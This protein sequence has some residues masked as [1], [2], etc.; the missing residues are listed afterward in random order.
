MKRKSQKKRNGRTLFS[1]DKIS[2]EVHRAVLRD[3]KPLYMSTRHEDHLVVLARRQSDEL[4]K[5][6]VGETTDSDLHESE[7][8]EAFIATNARLGRW[9]RDFTFPAPDLR[10]QRSM[11]TDTK[12]LLRARALIHFVL[13]PFDQDEWFDECKNSSGSSLGVPF[14]DTSPERKLT[15]PITVTE[16]A[17]PLFDQYLS[18]D[19][20]LAAA[21]DELNS[22]HPLSGRYEVV[23]GSRAT[24]VDKTNEK[25][26]MIAIEPTANM[27]LQQGL[28]ELLYKRLSRV[29]L[30]VETLPAAHKQLA[31]ESSITGENATIDFS[32][33]SDCVSVE[34]LRWLLPP[35]WFDVVYRTRSPVM[36]LRGQPESLNMISTMGN[37]VT[38]PLETLV[39]WAF[40]NG[41]VLSSN[42][43]TNSL[44][45][46]WED[47]MRCS[48]FGDDCIVPTPTAVSFME[49]MEK[50]GFV[51]NREK[52]FFDPRQKFRESCG[53]DYHAGYNVRPFHLKAPT[54][55]SMASL[56]PWLYIILNRLIPKYISCFGRLRYVYDKELFRV[57]AEVFKEH[58]LKLKLV[59]PDYP[60]DAGL[61]WSSDLQRFAACYEWNF[62]PIAR[63]HHGTYTFLACSFR[64]K[65]K[66]NRDDG[67]R[68]TMWLKKPVMAKREPPKWY[69]RR[70]IGG[71]VVVRGLSSSWTIPVVKR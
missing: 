43:R 26:R 41:T 33:A 46:E 36:T 49:I 32:S 21:V 61:R 6:Y 11:D 35:K 55:R 16:M 45:P 63:S 29:G 24:T 17:K 51:V 27:F 39:F 23:E 66:V 37:A 65:E 9:A 68:Y 59:P 20:Q 14:K 50:V 13:T 4:L 71:Y 7:A 38:F 34:L 25:R 12:T 69:K 53:G 42:P 48:V 54:N 40:A 47:L 70:R 10:I 64:Y 28:M 2:T 3:L 15:W 18:Y 57:I 8:F 44:F 52:S 67:I 58:K 19:F 56:E 60:E 5:K 31:L 62:S 22:R 30:D 1:P